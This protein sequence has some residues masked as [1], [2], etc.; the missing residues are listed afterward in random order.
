MSQTEDRQRGQPH[1]AGAMKT[2]IDGTVWDDVEL[3]GQWSEKRY[4]L[5]RQSK[6]LRFAL[7]QS[8]GVQEHKQVGTHRCRAS[9]TAAETG[10]TAAIPGASAHRRPDDEH[11]PFSFSESCRTILAYR[12]ARS[13]GMA[14][15]ARILLHASG[16]GRTPI[17]FVCTCL[18]GAAR[19][20]PGRGSRV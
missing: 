19:H 14:T 2:T 10:R 20:L 11:S 17:I 1:P 5:R 18:D 3:S 8:G 9:S 13:I 4:Q 15:A 16:H 12:L 6:L 7:S